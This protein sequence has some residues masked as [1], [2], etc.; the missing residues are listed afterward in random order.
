MRA[1]LDIFDRAHAYVEHCRRHHSRQPKRASLCLAWWGLLHSLSR[2]K[3]FSSEGKEFRVA[4]VIDGGLG[5]NLLHI[6]YIKDFCSQY[7]PFHL[8]VYSSLDP[9]VA[10][11][12][13]GGITNVASVRSGRVEDVYDLILY[14]LLVPMTV[15]YCKERLDKL[16]S[17]ALKT[18]VESLERFKA[19]N[20]HWF[21]FQQYGMA[22]ILN[23]ARITGT[24]R[25]AL[26][27]MI[28]DLQ[29]KTKP[30]LELELTRPDFP[31]GAK[32][33]V[34]VSRGSGATQESTKLWPVHRYDE[35]PRLLR[36]RFP[37]VIFVQTGDKHEKKLE[38]DY[39]LRGK[40]SFEELAVLMR[41]A[42]LH[43]SSEGGTVHL[44]HLLGGGPSA[45]FF[46][47]TDP[48][49][50]GYAENCNLRAEECT[51]CEWVQLDWQ[52]RCCRGFGVCRALEMLETE[53]V[54]QK[55]I[56]HPKA[57]EALCKIS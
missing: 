16:A 11:T 48:S 5:D 27:Y 53:E 10:R 39:D 38:V 43:I 56:K 26:P 20:S 19:K 30:F 34:T 6:R 32:T 31:W 49:F 35:C 50:Y 51:P 25:E 47:P 12:L 8:D 45:V 23:Y 2:E 28:G 42:A 57:L 15:S 37:G 22:G 13:F 52:K 7:G 24:K 4:M 3:R 41:D 46:G 55:I 29:L 40:T 9:L 36:R 1:H 33:F 54:V 18:Y 17:P 44:R 14:S 21:A